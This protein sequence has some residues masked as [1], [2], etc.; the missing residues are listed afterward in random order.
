[1]TVGIT[2]RE[3]MRTG[4]VLVFGFYLPARSRADST[5]G[6]VNA[7]ISITPDNQVT[8]FAETPRWDRVHEPPTP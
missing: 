7:W 5:D 6:K 2:R 4:A 8:L 3:A 1:M